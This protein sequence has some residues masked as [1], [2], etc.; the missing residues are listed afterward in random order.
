V[1]AD[2]ACGAQLQMTISSVTGL[3]KV[4][5]A[6]LFGSEGT[7]KFVNNTLYGGQRADDS[8]QEIEISPAE[9]GS[10]RVE[11]EFINSIQ[12]I[13]KITHTDFRT[14]AKYMEFT[15]AVT[16]SMQSGHVIALPLLSYP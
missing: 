14:G 11:E 8:L 10:W 16:R 4:N 9:A 6:W 3:A 7:L 2:L 13:E 15:E 5:E 1:L 12:G